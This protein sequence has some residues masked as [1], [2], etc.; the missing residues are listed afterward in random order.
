MYNILNSLIYFEFFKYMR[1]LCFGYFSESGYYIKMAIGKSR[2][3]F[4]FYVD[5]GSPLTWLHCK[6]PQDTNL[7]QLYVG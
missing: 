6:W 5:S 7:F 3:E 1:E 4:K 2:K